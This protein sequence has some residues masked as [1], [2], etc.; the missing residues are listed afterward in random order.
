MPSENQLSL[1]T[2]N[3]LE[4]TVSALAN[5]LKISWIWFPPLHLFWRFEGQCVCDVILTFKRFHFSKLFNRWPEFLRTKSVWGLFTLQKVFFFFNPF[6][7]VWTL[8]KILKAQ[9]TWCLNTA[10]SEPQLH[11]WRWAVRGGRWGS[12]G[13]SKKIIWWSSSRGNSLTLSLFNPDCTSMNIT[14]SRLQDLI[15]TN[16]NE[17]NVQN[18]ALSYGD[19]DIT[20][21]L[22]PQNSILQLKNWIIDQGLPSWICLIICFEWFAACS[23]Y[24]FHQLKPDPWPLA[25]TPLED[26]RK[27]LLCVVPLMNY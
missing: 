19:K 27:L 1:L 15:Y 16:E 22:K 7:A 24:H 12:G 26:T 14:Q 2:T 4:H 6:F 18:K 9:L 25:L 3:G 23:L 11:Q 21:C 8:A 20:E 5:A 10:V 17:A 13:D